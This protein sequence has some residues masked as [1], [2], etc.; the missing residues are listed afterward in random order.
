MPAFTDNRGNGSALK[1][2][3]TNRYSA[4]FGRHGVSDEM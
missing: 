3:M 1:Q 2:L 4:Y